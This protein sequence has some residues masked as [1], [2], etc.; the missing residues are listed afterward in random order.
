MAKAARTYRLSDFYTI[1]N[2]IRNQDAKCTDYLVGIGLEHWARSHF[3]G[4]RYDIMTSNVAESWNAVLREAREYPIIPLVEYI[5]SKLV[6]WFSIRR[7]AAMSNSTTLSPRVSNIVASK[8]ELCG[9][10]EVHKII[11]V[12]YEVRD[13]LGVAFHVDLGKKTCSCFKFQMLFIPCPNAIATAVQCN[14]QVDSLVGNAYSTETL[15]GAYNNPIFPVT[16]M[17]A[18]NDIGSEFS[19]FNVFPPS[20]RRPPGRPRKKRLFSRG[21]IRV[22]FKF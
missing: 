4:C 3:T 11:G 8:F 15:R 19:D 12:E 20:T 9:G 18:E 13:K 22:S 14:I 7:D 2:E 16:D 21:E 1:F 5:R 6:S 10:Y 17:D